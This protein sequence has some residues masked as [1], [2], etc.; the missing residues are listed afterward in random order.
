MTPTTIVREARADGVRL[1]LSTFGAIKASGDSAA[2]NRWVAVIRERK[3][4][5]I[6]A[7]KVGAGYTATAS[8]WWLIHFTD[9][10]PVETVFDPAVTHA[11]LLKW[12]RDAVAAEPLGL[13][14]ASLSA[15]MEAAIR[16]WLALVGGADPDATHRFL[17]LSDGETHR[18]VLEQLTRMR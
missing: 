6:E 16:Q 10:D 11:E 14:T 12:N 7:L 3:A 4:E 8:R 17:A 18:W 9:R 5:I 2:V 15:E 13:A 1:T